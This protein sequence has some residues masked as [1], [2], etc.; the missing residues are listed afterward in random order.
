MIDDFKAR[1][2]EIAT[3]T[4]DQW[5]PVVEPIWPC[6]YGRAYSAPCDKEAILNLIAHLIIVQ[7]TAGT[8]AAKSVDSKSVGSVSV[9]YSGSTQTGGPLYD[10]FRTTKYG[11]M[12]LQVTA[13]SRGA[14]FV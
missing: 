11:L 2:P 8:A 3:A 9:S 12:F 14:F 5:F 6:Y 10:F 4:V 13:S 1:F 7:S